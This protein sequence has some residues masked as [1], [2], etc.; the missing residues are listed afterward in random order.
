MSDDSNEYDN[1]LEYLCEYAPIENTSHVKLVYNDK[2][3]GG[4]VTVP[5]NR[6]SIPILIEYLQKMQAIKE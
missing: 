4:N 2:I 1:Y 6:L 5:L 3:L